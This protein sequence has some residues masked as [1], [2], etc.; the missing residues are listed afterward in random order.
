[1]P[2]NSELDYFSDT[3]SLSRAGTLKAFGRT[4]ELPLRCQLGFT[5]QGNHTF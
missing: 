4:Y 3:L 5:T 1:M 2:L